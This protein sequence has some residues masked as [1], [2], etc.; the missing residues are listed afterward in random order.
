MEFR[1]KLNPP[2]LSVLTVVSLC[3][4]SD[5]PAGAPDES[6]LSVPAKSMQLSSDS[7]RLGEPLFSVGGGGRPFRA[8]S[9]FGICAAAPSAICEILPEATPARQTGGAVERAPET[10]KGPMRGRLSPPEEIVDEFVEVSRLPREWRCDLLDPVTADHAFDQMGVLDGALPW[11]R[12]ARMS[13]GHRRTSRSPC[14]RTR[15]ATG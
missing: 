15:P 6:S 8:P 10:G 9:R 7:I 12:T 14:P 4:C 1:S 5:A 3:G 13:T 2:L 11:R